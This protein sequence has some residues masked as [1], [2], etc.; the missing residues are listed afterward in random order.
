VAVRQGRSSE[1]ALVQS[2]Q[3]VAEDLIATYKT[4]GGG[5]EPSPD[6]VAAR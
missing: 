1:S 5:W 6:R 2:D 3:A 4:L